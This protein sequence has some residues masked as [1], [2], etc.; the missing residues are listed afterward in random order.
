MINLL[1]AGQTFIKYGNY[2]NPHI[3]FVRLSEDE[4]RITWEAISSCSLFNRVKYIE[5]IHVMYRLNQLKDVY[6]GY[7]N[8]KIFEKYKIPPDFDSCCFSIASSS[9]TLD[10]RNDDESICRKWYQAI[11]FLIKRTKSISEFQIN[12]NNLKEIFNKKEVIVD[13]WKT[14][15]LPNWHN[16]RKFILLKENRID[17]AIEKKKKNLK[18]I[19]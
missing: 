13:I 1:K 18:L 15:I 2:G 4:K 3:R 8:S 12:K 6:I 11:K 14:E 19:C 10:L 9:R 16:Y 7:S 17:F 5:T